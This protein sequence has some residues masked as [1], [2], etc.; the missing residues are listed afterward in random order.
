MSEIRQELAREYANVEYILAQTNIDEYL[1]FIKEQ[2]KSPF[3]SGSVNYFRKMIKLITD[4]DLKQEYARR[5]LEIIDNEYPNL[6]VDISEVDSSLI[7]YAEALYKFFGKNLKKLVNAFFREY[8]FNNKNRKA[9]LSSYQDIKISSYPKEQFGKKDNYILVLKIVSILEDIKEL[10]IKIEEF[11]D[12]CVRNN[13]KP[14]YIDG[15]EEM[16]E[17]D[18]ISDY[19]IFDDIMSKFFKSD[20]FDAMVNTLKIR[21]IDAIVRPSVEDMGY[22]SVADTIEVED[23]DDDEEEEDDPDE[24]PDID[25]TPMKID[26]FEGD[27]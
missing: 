20:S 18:I 7:D 15:F 24:V 2:V 5:V 17:E 6:D 23:E 13:D 12:Y 16:I 10:P 8:L 14:R 9:L 4:K 27:D 11:I 21:L 26:D 3:D 1:E 19:G 25:E 22:G